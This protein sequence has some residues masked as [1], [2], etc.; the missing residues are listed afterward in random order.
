MSDQD[1]EYRGMMA[2]TWDLWRNDTANWS[3]RALFLDL[4]RQH[5]QPALDIGCG[6]GRIALD[7]LSHGIDI[8]G[9]DNSPEMLAICRE[10][11]GKMGLSPA[12]YQQT[13]EGLDLPR[14]YRTILVPSSSFQLLVDRAAADE[15]MRR[16]F[17]HLEPGGALVMPFYLDWKEGDPLQTEWSVLW[18][19]VRPEDGATVRR[20]ARVRYDPAEQ[21]EH[22][23]DRYEITLNDRVIASESHARSPATRWYS[24]SQAA[25]L[26]RDAGFAQI[27]IL[28][29]FQ[30]TPATEADTLFTIVGT[31][32]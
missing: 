14:A 13:M 5:G 25:R 15:A 26:Y 18:E 23:E 4:V 21:F 6:T 22:T 8:D 32:L 29:G 20:Y 1:Y 10:K 12:L 30:R 7:F 24:Q 17:R 27:E 11:A 31:R 2:A 19:R 28:S 16:F 3:D 9:V